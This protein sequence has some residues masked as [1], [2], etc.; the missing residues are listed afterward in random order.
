MLK[1]KEY[2]L[3][4]FNKGTFVYILKKN[5]LASFGRKIEK[6]VY[7]TGWKKECEISSM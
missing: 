1:A 4:V 2:T 7:L 6:T 3:G 5:T